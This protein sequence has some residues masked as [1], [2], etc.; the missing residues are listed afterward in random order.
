MQP[1]DDGY[2]IFDIQIV[3]GGARAPGPAAGP[4]AGLPAA[5]PARARDGEDH[6]VRPHDSDGRGLRAPPRD[7]PAFSDERAERFVA[8]LMRATPRPRR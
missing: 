2:T 6:P 7:S 8:P 4:R 1:A 3:C 5:G